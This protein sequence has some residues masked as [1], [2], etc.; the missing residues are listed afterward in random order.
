[1]LRLSK[2]FFDFGDQEI[3]Q[4]PWTAPRTIDHLKVLDL[5]QSF[6][7]FSSHEYLLE[8]PIAPL[9][10]ALN[11]VSLLQGRRDHRGR[12]VENFDKT[13]WKNEKVQVA[14]QEIATTMKFGD[15]IKYVPFWCLDRLLGLILQARFF[16]PGIII[17]HELPLP[18][19]LRME[20]NPPNYKRTNR[21]YVF[22][23]VLLLKRFPDKGY[24]WNLVLSQ[25]KDIPRIYLRGYPPVISLRHWLQSRKKSEQ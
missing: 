4:L 6:K 1:M 12:H 10:N 14:L 22:A 17:G 3:I 2:K 9:D 16:E 20:D 13:I 5:S 25:L 21:Y 15:S 7:L 24:F 11:F 8:V 23:E 18:E 19:C